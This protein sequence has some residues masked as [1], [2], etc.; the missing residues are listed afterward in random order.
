MPSLSIPAS[1]QADFL[2]ALTKASLFLTFIVI[3]LAVPGLSYGMWYLWSSLWHAGSLVVACKLLAA[4][5]GIRF[6]NQGS[7]PDPLCWERRVIAR[8]LGK[9][10]TKASQG[11]SA[12]L[13]WPPGQGPVSPTQVLPGGHTTSGA[14]GT[15]LTTG[16]GRT[17]IGCSQ[18]Q[19]LWSKCSH[20]GWFQAI[21]LS[22]R[23]E[24]GRAAQTS[25]QYFSRIFTEDVNNLK[26][27]DN[28]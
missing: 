12:Q 24:W 8:P 25:G 6:P 11:D 22:H 23:A 18:S 2:N 27:I 13:R 7:N 4:P 9:S 14:L 3:Y 15:V 17:G 21:T 19:Y 1:S 20:H 28:S 26:S 16:S 10:L 5:C